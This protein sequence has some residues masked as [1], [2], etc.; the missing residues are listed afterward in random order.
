MMIIMLK[1]VMIRY[2]APYVESVNVHKP[3]PGSGPSLFGKIVFKQ[4]RIPA[5]LMGS[6]EKIYYIVEGRHLY[7]K[8]FISQTTKPTATAG[9]SPP[10]GGNH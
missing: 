4:E 3:K 1:L 7:C 8:R 2:Y 9:T 5:F 10:D 6:N